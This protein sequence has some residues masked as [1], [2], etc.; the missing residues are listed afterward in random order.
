[1][2]K[3][4][5]LASL[6]AIA[7]AIFPGFFVGELVAGIYSYLM[8]YLAGAA[9]GM[10]RVILVHWLAG[11]VAG[12]IIGHLAIAPAR[13]LFKSAN[14]MAAA[15]CVAVFAVAV[16]T[17][18]IYLVVTADKPYIHPA[19]IA[20]RAVGVILAAYLAAR[21]PKGERSTPGGASS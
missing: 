17:V 16:G 4:T 15:H 19:A 6:A 7:L 11:L 9:P 5:V 12:V 13:Y 18:W 21:A 10:V 8:G 14:M 20:A 2:S 3:T 1:M